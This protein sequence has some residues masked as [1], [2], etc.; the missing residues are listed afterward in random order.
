MIPD[1]ILCGITDYNVRARLLRDENLSLNKA[2]VQ[3]CRAAERSKVQAQS[4]Q[5]SHTNNVNVCQVDRLTHK[6]SNHDKSNRSNKAKSDQVSNTFD[7]GKLVVGMGQDCALPMV[8][9][10]SVRS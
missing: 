2:A 1:R 10:V 4:P 8:K 9:N 6:K 5:E 7:C 3:T